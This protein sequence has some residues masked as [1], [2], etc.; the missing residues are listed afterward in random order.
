MISLIDNALKFTDIGSVRLKVW[1]LE[2]DRLQFEVKDTG[3]GIAEDQQQRLSEAF[4][5]LDESNTRS[6]GGSGLGLSI[7][8]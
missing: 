7:S 5:Q 8:R 2:A 3:P 6:Q 1:P 4:T